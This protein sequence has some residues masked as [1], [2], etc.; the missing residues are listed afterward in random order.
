MQKK[1]RQRPKGV[2]ILAILMML[3]GIVSMFG[4]A[5]SISGIIALALGVVYIIMGYGLFKGKGWA[6]IGTIVSFFIGIAISII[7][8]VFSMAITPAA[9]N[10]VTSVS[11]ILSIYLIGLSIAIAFAVIIIYYLYRPHVKAYFGR[12]AINTPT[13]ASGP[14]N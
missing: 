14:S 1:Y 11:L 7:S 2:T 6:W 8:T 5:S 3:S 4:I 10:G 13:T 9:T 12:T